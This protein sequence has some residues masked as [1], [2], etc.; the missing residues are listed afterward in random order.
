MKKIP[1]YDVPVGRTFVFHH[2]MYRRGGLY[3]FEGGNVLAVPCV[4]VGVIHNNVERH[5]YRY[6]RVEV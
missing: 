6:I 2:R 1:L 3:S 4:P 5:I